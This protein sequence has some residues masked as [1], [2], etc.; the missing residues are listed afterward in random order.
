MPLISA[1]ILSLLLVSGARAPGRQ[2]AEQLARSGRHAEALKQFQAMAAANPDDIEARIWIARLHTWMGNHARGLE[3]YRSVVATN[4]QNVEALIGVGM[5][6]TTLGRLDEAADALARAEALAADQPSVLAAQGRLHAAANRTTLALA[7]YE[8]ALALQP[9]D[10]PVRAEYD[11]VRAARAHRVDVGYLYER[12]DLGPVDF[13]VHGVAVEA[14]AR[15]SDAVRLFARGHYAHV[16]SSDESRGGAGVEWTARPGVWLR[17]GAM[18]GGD[19]F[20][21][22]TDVFFEA[23]GGQGRVRVG[24]DLRFAD[25][26][27][28]DLWVGGPRMTAALTKRVDLFARYQFSRATFAGVTNAESHNNVTVGVN[29]RLTPRVRATASYRRG[30]DRLDWLT[31]D[32]LFSGEANTVSF[33]ASFDATPFVTIHGAYDH[34]DRENVSA[35]RIL[36]RL[37]YRF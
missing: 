22:N 12:A 30:I 21:P 20:L 14:N 36:G 4:P 10:A 9:N 8:R 27:G 11:A 23:D 1:A 6:L 29:G 32:R 35:N 31:A 2:A 26:D 3:V 28:A 7:Y 33:G 18:F 34:Q 37:T 16:D 13:D 5:A 25:F 19:S 15:V 24:G 17:A